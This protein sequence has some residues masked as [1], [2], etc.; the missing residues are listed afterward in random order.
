MHTLNLLAQRWE[1]DVGAMYQVHSGPLL[2]QHIGAMLV[3][4]SILFIM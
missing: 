4:N 1:D 2:T 3:Q